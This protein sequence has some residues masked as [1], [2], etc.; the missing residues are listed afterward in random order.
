M[1][2]RE[3]VVRAAR[4]YV[5]NRDLKPKVEERLAKASSRMESYLLRNATE[6]ACLGRYRVELVDGELSVSELPPEGWEQ[7]EMGG[8]DGDKRI[9]GGLDGQS[10]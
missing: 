9:G 1:K 5:Y 10:I 2:E 7:L 3:R 8:F 4:S 6:S